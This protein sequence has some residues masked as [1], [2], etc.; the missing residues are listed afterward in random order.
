MDQKEKNADQKAERA[1]LEKILEKSKFGDLADTLV[2]YE[3][4]KMLSRT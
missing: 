1:M 2:K 3:G 4:E